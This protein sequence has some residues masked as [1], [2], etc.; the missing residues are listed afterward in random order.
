LYC[1]KSTVLHGREYYIRKKTNIT[2]KDSYSGMKHKI[3]SQY[4]LGRKNSRNLLKGL[5]QLACITEQSLAVSFPNMN[6]I[7]AGNQNTQ[8]SEFEKGKDKISL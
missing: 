4:G 3:N 8:T 5:H 1:H 7:K 6:Y 2:R